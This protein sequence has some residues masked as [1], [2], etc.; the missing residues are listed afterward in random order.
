[1]AD[2]INS[3]KDLKVFWKAV[4]L[5]K[6]IYVLTKEFLN[7]ERFG[8]TSQIRRAAVS[9]SSNIAEGW[10]SGTRKQFI[11]GLNISRGSLLEVEAQLIIAK[12][13]GFLS[14]ITAINLTIVELAKMLN[15]LKRC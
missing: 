4:S 15:S 2:K 3:Y 10:G 6:D 13:L 1:M 8:L 9:I 11:N 5:A 12:E 7:D 14:D